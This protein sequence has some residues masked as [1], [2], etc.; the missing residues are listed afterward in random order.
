M[1]NVRPTGCGTF[2][3]SSLACK[4]AAVRVCA[5]AALA[6]ALLLQPPRAMAADTPWIVPAGAACT[7]TLRVAN[8]IQWL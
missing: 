3:R 1:I 4:R 6:L 2:V 5:M 7:P 8:S